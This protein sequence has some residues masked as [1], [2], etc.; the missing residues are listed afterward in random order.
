MASKLRLIILG[1]PGSGKGTI[2]SRLVKEF[3]LNHLSSG[4]LLRSNIERKTEIGKE[5]KD[6]VASGKLLPDD[7]ITKLV[8]KELRL[9]VNSSW[10]LD[11][12]PRTLSQ[13]KSLD[14]NKFTVDRV[15]NLNV[16]FDEII[17]RLKHRWVHPPSGRVYNLEFN[18]PKVA[19]KDDVTGD[20]LIQ[21]P[22][23]RE[24]VVLARLKVYEKQTQ[25]IVDYYKYVIHSI[26]LFKN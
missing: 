21:R 20:P 11:G 24:D 13:A 12:F 9:L 25:P 22:D 8:I 5:A 6:Y 26:F 18:P 2:S 19:M 23:D 4:D 3:R 16:P 17:N 10:L 15:I 7:F 14:D 1:A